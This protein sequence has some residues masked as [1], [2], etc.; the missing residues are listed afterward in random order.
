MGSRWTSESEA[1]LL[2]RTSSKPA[3]FQAIVR[4]CLKGVGVG[5]QSKNK[6]THI[7][8]E[9]NRPPPKANQIKYVYEM[10]RYP[11][12]QTVDGSLKELGDGGMGNYY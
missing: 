7:P 12:R 10:S 5:E 1:I 4:P 6:N 8:R 9:R 3:N 2:Y 11:W